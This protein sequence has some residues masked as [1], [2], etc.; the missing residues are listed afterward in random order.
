MRFFTCT[1][2]ILFLNTSCAG[3]EISVE[4][5]RDDMRGHI[6]H[7]VEVSVFDGTALKSVAVSGNEFLYRHG[8]TLNYS[9]VLYFTG[10]GHYPETIIFNAKKESFKNDRV[11]LTPLKN[12][13]EGVLTGV[14]YKP[15][16]G[17]KRIEHKGIARL[18]GNEK[19]SIVNN[20]T[21]RE[22][23][24]DDNGVFMVGLLPGEYDIFF[25]NKQVSRVLIENS[26]TTIRNIQKGILLID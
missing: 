4:I 16:S 1:I 22:V 2:L 11:S 7:R 18:F 19:V 25:N 3:R 23:V 20:D 13:E 12:S 10:Q 17:G 24:T 9:G 6:I 5:N 21:A 15:V 26:K 8:I 14:V